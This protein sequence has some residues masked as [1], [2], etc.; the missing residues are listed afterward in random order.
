MEI[1]ENNQQK[2]EPLSPET[3]VAL[4]RLSITLQRMRVD[5]CKKGYAIIDGVLVKT[6]D[7]QQSDENKTGK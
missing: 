5:L 4:E 6:S 7:P 2:K 3:L 1:P